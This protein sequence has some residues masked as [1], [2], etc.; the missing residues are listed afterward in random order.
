MGSFNNM[1]DTPDT[2]KIVR[3][4]RD[5][6]R[7]AKLEVDRLKEKLD[8]AENLQLKYLLEAKHLREQLANAGHRGE[9]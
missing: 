6:L 5:N 4:L 3:K 7:A 2:R 8:E 1:T 9:Q